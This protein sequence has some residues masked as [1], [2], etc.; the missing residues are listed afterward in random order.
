M[1]GEILDDLVENV[2]GSTP[3]ETMDQVTALRGSVP[4]ELLAAFGRLISGRDEPALLIRGF[5]VDDRSI[6]PTPTHWMSC[7]PLQVDSIIR[8]YELLLVLIAQSIGE[9]FGYGSLQGG[10]LVHNVMPMAGAET[11]Q[12]GHGS[13]AVL[14]WHTEDAFTSLRA[15]YLALMGLRNTDAVATTI[16]GISALEGLDSQDLQV[17]KEPRFAIVPD[18][19]HLRSTSP[20]PSNSILSGFA[21]PAVIPVLY[22]A[23]R[24]LRMVIDS[25]Y[26]T[27]IDSVAEASFGRA[28]EALDAALERV[29]VLPGDVLLIDNHRAV[30]GREDFPAR[31]DGTDRWLL[32]VS[33]ACT[34]EP[35]ARHRA[36]TSSR[37]LL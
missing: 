2:T 17:L 15:D 23:P 28:V 10:R 9:L 14:A 33:V 19:E 36:G 13:E 1:I 35:S 25:V 5:A 4:T 32:K 21:A 22:E 7:R 37:I 6:G 3:E 16:A 34:L 29:A 27:P 18:D 31:Y 30:H 8:R 24:G 11:D 26:M 20:R 12:S